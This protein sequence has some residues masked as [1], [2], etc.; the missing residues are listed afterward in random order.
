MHLVHCISRVDLFQNWA[1]LLLDI[2]FKAEAWKRSEDVAK[3]D[4]PS[5]GSQV[6]FPVVTD[7]LD[8]RR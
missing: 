7:N 3:E 1:L 8:L 5:H 2:E 4:T 6:S